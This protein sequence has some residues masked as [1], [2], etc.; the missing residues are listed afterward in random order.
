MRQKGVQ[1]DKHTFPLLLKTLSKTIGH[2]PFMLYAQIFKLGF[3]LDLFV[4]NTL[5]PAF[6]NSG[7]M[8]SA[9]QVFDESPFKGTVA[10][11]ALIN[12]ALMDMYFKCGLC[13]DACKVFNEMPYRNVVCWTVLV[14][15]YV[16]S[17]K[18]QDALRAFWDMLLD[19]VVPNDFTFS[20]VLTACAHMGALDQGRLVHE[21]IESNKIN[22][23]AELGTAL[24]DMYAKCG[25]IDDALRV[26]ENLPV[27]NVYTWTAIIHGLAVHGDAIGALHMFSCMLKSGIQPNEVTFVGV[28]AACS[29]GGFVEEGKRLFEL[30]R[31]SYNLKPEMDH[32]GCMVDMLGRAGYLEDAKQIIDNMP[33][34]PSP[35][36]L[37]ALFGACMVHKDFEMGEHIG[38]LLVN[39]KPNDSGSYALLT[40]LYKMCQNWEAAAQVRKVMKGLQVEKTPGYSWIEVDGFNS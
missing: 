24:V 19:D 22:L 37:G 15:G 5:I 13:E 3:D 14:A 30:M 33:M 11:T 6:A 18:F 9:R 7:F 29:H 26:F 34:K 8:E 20:S 2:H 39:Q 23:N 27:K 12:G 4:S 10:W 16:Q 25:C 1:P 32:Y 36:V 35:G 38:I 40:N 21:Y 17:N 28:L 31:H